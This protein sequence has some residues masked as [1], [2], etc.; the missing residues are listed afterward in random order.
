[1]RRMHLALLAVLVCA[2]GAAALRS[3]PVPVADGLPDISGTWSGKSHVKHTDQSTG[4]N[5]V[6][7]SF[8]IDCTIGQTGNAVTLDITVHVAGGG[9]QQLELSGEEGNGIFWA[10]GSDPD[11]AKPV[12]MVGRVKQNHISAKG[13]FPGVGISEGTFSLNRSN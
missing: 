13:L 3:A 2:G 12:L 10:S 9:T 8:P 7:I 5:V 1:M 4:G 11:T 6:K